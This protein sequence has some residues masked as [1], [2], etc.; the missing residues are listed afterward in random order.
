MSD[1]ALSS[2]RRSALADWIASPMNPLTARVMVN[3]LWQHHFGVGIVPT[4]DDFGNAGLPPTNQLLLDDLAARFVASGWSLKAMHRLIMTSAAYRQSSRS[5][6]STAFGIDPDNTLLWR[7]N[8]RRV[9]A[10]VIRD[11]MLSVSGTLNVKQGGPSVFPTLPPLVHGDQDSSR[12]DWQDSPD[13]E[14][15]R[16]SVYLVVKRGLRIPLL[17]SF[18][19]ANGTSPTGVRPI[20]TTA[21]Q[22]LML[23]NDRF[24]QEQAEHLASRVVT[25]AGPE[26]DAQITRAF[27][28]VV[29][30]DP[31]PT[32]RHAALKL[33]S[34]LPTPSVPAGSDGGNHRGL[35][36]LCH[37]LLNIN[38]FIYAD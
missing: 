21:P 22:S 37:G 12:K 29:Q 13:S 16:R 18:D 31:E 8:L 34:S 23:L 11:S 15:D 10:E 1:D 26:I 35:I 4:P 3:R 27:H 17:D 36:A 32:E 7:Q 5:D 38:E 25:E 33:L 19:F 20:T 6:N 2:G 14:Q 9:D 30:R 28:L 24:V